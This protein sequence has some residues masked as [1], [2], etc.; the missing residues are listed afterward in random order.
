ME[1]HCLDCIID[2]LNG[3]IYCNNKEKIEILINELERRIGMGEKITL[4]KSYIED[5][6]NYI[7][8]IDSRNPIK[9]L[10]S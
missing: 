9:I 6:I 4:E 5:K 2:K 1:E 10:C 3:A 7:I 8:K